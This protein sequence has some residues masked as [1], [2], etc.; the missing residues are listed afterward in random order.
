MENINRK[1]LII[2]DSESLVKVTIDCFETFYTGFVFLNKE[3][4]TSTNEALEIINKNP[5]NIILLDHELS[6]SKNGGLEIA[7]K[8]AGKIKNDDIL[9]LSTS[10][11]VS[12]SPEMI[13]LYKE[14]GV[15]HFSGKNFYEIKE[16]LD[17][18]CKCHLL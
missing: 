17:G 12:I 1:I 14:K 11:L 15:L 2:E 18:L 9:V 7:E 5:C 10:M 16:C 13:G 6:D 3:P 4:I 8:I